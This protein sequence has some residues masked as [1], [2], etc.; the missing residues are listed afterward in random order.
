MDAIW[1]LMAFLVGVCGPMQAGVNGALTQN[2]TQSSLITGALSAG[3]TSL[4]LMLC[5]V[6]FRHPWPTFQ[7]VPWWQYT[8]CLFG[9]FILV[10]MTV[11]GTRLGASSFVALLLAGQIVTAVLVDHFGLAGY[12]VRSVSA[13]RVVGLLLI[14]AGVLVVRRF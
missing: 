3:V 13:G 1:V 8:G 11:T 6:L 5:A 7:S 12:A 4:L 14:A 9:A 10:G 2:W